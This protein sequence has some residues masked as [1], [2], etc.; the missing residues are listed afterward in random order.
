[1]RLSTGHGADI[2]YAIA[3]LGAHIKNNG[4][5]GWLV[6]GRGFDTLLTL[7]LGWLAAKDI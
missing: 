7:E 2:F 5:P 6:L 3:A 4:P 1:M